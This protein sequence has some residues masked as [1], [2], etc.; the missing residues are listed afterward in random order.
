V[1]GLAASRPDTIAFRDPD[2]ATR[3]ALRSLD[4]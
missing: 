2:A 3:I 4:G 1:R